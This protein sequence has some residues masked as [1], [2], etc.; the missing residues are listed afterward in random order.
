MKVEW[1]NKDSIEM[2]TTT[3]SDYIKREDAITYLQEVKKLYASN[4]RRIYQIID[5]LSADVVEVVRCKDCTLC[6]YL[7]NMAKL[8]C[9]HHGGIVQPDDYCNYGE[10]EQE[11]E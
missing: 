9:S 8:S 6:V 1:S 2:P 4:D 5:L 11:H 10:K 3:T 7:Q